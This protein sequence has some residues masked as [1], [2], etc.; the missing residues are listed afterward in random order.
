MFFM[1][2]LLVI[3]REDPLAAKIALPVLGAGVVFLFGWIVSVP[4]ALVIAGGVHWFLRSVGYNTRFPYLL[5][6]PIVGLFGAMVV[7]LAIPDLIGDLLLG[8]WPTFAYVIS[9]C[10]GG[11]ILMWVF[12]NIRRPD[13]PWDDLEDRRRAGEIL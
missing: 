11:T 9:W 1:T 12:W 3:P 7:H 6:G 8:G 5:A 10:L 4:M 13:R 2:L